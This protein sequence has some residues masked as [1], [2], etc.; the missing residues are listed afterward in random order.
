MVFLFGFTSY[1]RIVQ[2]QIWFQVFYL[3]AQTKHNCNENEHE[4][5]Y[6]P[7]IQDPAKTERHCQIFN[8]HK[9]PSPNNIQQLFPCRRFAIIGALIPDLDRS[10]TDRAKKLSFQIPFH[11]TTVLYNNG[12]ELTDTFPTPRLLQQ[13]QHS[14]WK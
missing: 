14:S 2:N 13:G 8:N 5:Q 3:S 10:S 12:N 7:K 9:K 4:L 11:P 6:F 1:P